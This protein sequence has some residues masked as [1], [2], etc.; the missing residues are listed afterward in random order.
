[1]GATGTRSA[2]ASRR[3]VPYPST[4]PGENGFLAHFFVP[5]TRIPAKFRGIF[6]NFQV[7]PKKIRPRYYI[8]AVLFS[9]RRTAVRLYTSHFHFF[10]NPFALRIVFL[11]FSNFSM[12]MAFW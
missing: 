6:F 9:R 3:C 4:I 12:R 1:M 10:K 8:E 2:F 11:S 7:S 5:K